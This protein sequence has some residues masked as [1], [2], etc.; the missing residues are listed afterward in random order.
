[1]EQEEDK[2]TTGQKSTNT[3]NVFKVLASGGEADLH[4]GFHRHLTTPWLTW[5][6]VLGG[7]SHPAV[8]TPLR[9]R[10]YSDIKGDTEHPTILGKRRAAGRQTCH[11]LCLQENLE[12]FL[13]NVNNQGAK[14]QSHD[15]LVGV[16]GRCLEAATQLIAELNKVSWPVPKSQVLQTRSTMGRFAKTAVRKGKIDRLYNEL[17]DAQSVMESGLA[18]RTRSNVD[19]LQLQQG[20]SFQN[21]DFKLQDLIANI[22]TSHQD[23]KV[24]D[25]I[26]TNVR[27]ES[28]LTNIIIEDGFANLHHKSLSKQLLQSLHYEG[29]NTRLN[30]M[31]PASSETFE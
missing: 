18:A 16:V 26:S 31:S 12:A 13:Q 8:R 30:Q 28:Q 27:Q 9:D 29:L 3:S 19:S 4:F 2:R 7:G 11:L 14:N 5:V 25:Q 21:P 10:C 24:V 20:A 15:E 6:R 17:K 23:N 22:I 1:M